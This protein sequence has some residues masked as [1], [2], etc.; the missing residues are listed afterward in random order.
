MITSYSILT[1]NFPQRN[2]TTLTANAKPAS[3]L[4]PQRTVFSIQ[5]LVFFAAEAEYSCSFFLPI[6]GLQY[7]C[8]YSYIMAHEISVLLTLMALQ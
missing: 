8:D 3:P 6:L 7:S 1:C 4:L 5:I 2:F